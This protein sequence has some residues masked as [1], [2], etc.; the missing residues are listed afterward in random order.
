MG[1][2][3]TPGACKDEIKALEDSRKA[4]EQA[5]LAFDSAK[6]NMQAGGI[7]TGAAGA[8]ALACTLATAGVGAVVCLGGAGL[9]MIGGLLWTQSAGEGLILAQE[10]AE[11]AIAAAEKA[12]TAACKCF[13]EHTVSTPD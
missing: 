7:S 2:E 11:G 12:I 6:H 13:S 8:G 10:Q 4:L 1:E 3:L 5:K 9:A